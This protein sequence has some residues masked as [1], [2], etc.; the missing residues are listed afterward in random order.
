MRARTFVRART[1][2]RAAN[3]RQRYC[4]CHDEELSGTESL[5]RPSADYADV[6]T[7]R[8]AS[9]HSRRMGDRGRGLLEGRYR[10]P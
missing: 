9:R 5:E 4:D 1:L 10:A 8:D 3:R 2:F 6:T 7:T